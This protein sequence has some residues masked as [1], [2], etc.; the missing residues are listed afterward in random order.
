MK[1]IWKDVK[2]YEE[3]YQVSNLGRVRSLDRLDGANHRLKGSIMKGCEITGGYLGVTL[4]KNSVVSS[5]KIHR[6]VAEAFIPNSEHKPQVNHINEDKTNNMVS[7]LEWMTAKENNNHGTRNERIGRA[8][9][10]SK[11]IPIIAT[12]IKTGESTEFYGTREC[13][14]QLGLYQSTITRVL[15]GKYKQTGGYTFEYAE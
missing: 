9:S 4:Y 2:G 8:V 14:R 15:Q 1:E 12:N 5:K 11:S 6:L 3:L 13:A 7:N 10:K